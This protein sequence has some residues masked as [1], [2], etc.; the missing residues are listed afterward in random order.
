MI[1]IYYSSD[2]KWVIFWEEGL[3]GGIKYTLSMIL[4]N[5]LSEKAIYMYLNVMV[6][7]QTPNLY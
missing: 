5:A 4:Q 2:F 1:I 3:T 6:Y 7:H